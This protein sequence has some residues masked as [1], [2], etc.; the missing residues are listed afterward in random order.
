MTDRR[1]V[2]A[3]SALLLVGASAYARAPGHAAP[4]AA[5]PAHGPTQLHTAARPATPGGITAAPPAAAG[6]ASAARI[7]MPASL[8]APAQS[9]TSQQALAMR[10]TTPLPTSARA[11]YTRGK[12]ARAL[13]NASLGGPATFDARKLVRR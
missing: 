10:A 3:A 11:P 7:P 1:L 6:R 4:R 13:V 2:I 9:L 12:S 5:P 8:R